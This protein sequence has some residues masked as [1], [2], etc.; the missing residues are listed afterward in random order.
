MGHPL[1][2]PEG[3]PRGNRGW[4]SLIRVDDEAGEGAVLVAVASVRFAP[5]Q[6]DENFVPRIQVQDHAIA[7]V[8]VVL[9]CVLGD[10]AGPHLWGLGR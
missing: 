10:G 6:F 3:E 5:I 7:S 1:P 2:H 8:V 4:R 9:V